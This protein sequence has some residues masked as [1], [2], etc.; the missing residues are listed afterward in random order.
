[1]SILRRRVLTGLVAGFGLMLTA[2]STP[3]AMDTETAADDATI[4][5]LVRHAE[6]TAER[7]DPELTDA[8][9][10]RAEALAD[11]LEDAGL[12]AIYS[13]DYIRTRDT[14]APIAARTGLDVQ[15]YDASDMSV[16]ADQLKTMNGHILVSGHS[17]TTPELVDLLGGDYVSP[18]VEAGENDRLYI[19]TLNEDGTASSVLERYGV[20][21]VLADTE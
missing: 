13:S 5:Y 11:R 14:A 20:R 1:M 15:I 19:V 4:I 16:L 6:K 8:G 3:A 9:K 12:T 21:F 18:I 10:A 7:P 2:C 17:N